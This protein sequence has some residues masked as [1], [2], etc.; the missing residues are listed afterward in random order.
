MWLMTDKIVSWDP[1]K[2]TYQANQ[3]ASCNGNGFLFEAALLYYM[4]YQMVPE[5]CTTLL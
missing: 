4:H 2:G 1:S 5:W 3:N